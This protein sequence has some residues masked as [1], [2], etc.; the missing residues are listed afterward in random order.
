MRLRRRGRIS[1]RKW[2]LLGLGKA[3]WWIQ[4]G[5]Y[6][7]YIRIPM[8]IMR[9]KC[10]ISEFHCASQQIPSRIYTPVSSLCSDRDFLQKDALS[11]G[12]NLP[13]CHRTYPQMISPAFW[14]DDLQSR[15]RNRYA[16]HCPN[17]PKSTPLYAG[18]RA[19]LA[20]AGP[21]SS[22]A[23]FSFFCSLSL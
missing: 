3:L 10:L 4:S 2:N 22:F 18:F 17:P 13:K 8:K 12:C 1:R 5:S 19:N 9:G 16:L 11:F 21:N 6:D 23:A 20:K 14:P 7:P 15:T